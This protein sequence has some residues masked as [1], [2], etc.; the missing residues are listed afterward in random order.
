MSIPGERFNRPRA[1]TRP[2]P[3]FLLELGLLPLRS[4]DRHF[5]NCEALLAG[6]GQDPDRGRGRDEFEDDRD[7]GSLRFSE[8]EDDFRRGSV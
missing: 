5:P 3:R 4:I 6:N 7:S 2:R 1:R 8:V